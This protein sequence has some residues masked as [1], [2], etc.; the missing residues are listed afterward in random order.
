MTM[1]DVTTKYYGPNNDGIG[2]DARWIN[3]HNDYLRTN[4][5]TPALEKYV[6]KMF[7]KIGKTDKVSR[8]NEKRLDYKIEEAKILIEVTSIN[9]AIKHQI[10]NTEEYL[11]NLPKNEEELIEK[12]D[13]AIEH[14]EEKKA[15]NN[16]YRRIGVI[17]FDKIY[18]GIG[19]RLL[20]SCHET[21]LIYATNFI[22]SNM[23]ALILLF[24]L[25]EN[26]E[27]GNLPDNI[28]FLRNSKV[29]DLLERLKIEIKILET[30]YAKN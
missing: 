20:R 26:N 24:S 27:I 16:N 15:S 10:D 19:K 11:I 2:A 14:I 5:Q 23:D 22:T 18:Q 17:Y 25:K 6:K 4:F 3:A 1:E 28:L 12:I 30:N 21:N 13:R 8:D 7:S 29:H 9:W